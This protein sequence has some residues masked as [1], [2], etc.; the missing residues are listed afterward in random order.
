M[1]TTKIKRDTKYWNIILHFILDVFIIL[2]FYALMKTILDFYN[3][4][5]I[6]ILG[7]IYGITWLNKRYD[8]IFHIKQFILIISGK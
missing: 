4:W 3:Y 6:T 8:I 7:I 5:F 1:K 2:G